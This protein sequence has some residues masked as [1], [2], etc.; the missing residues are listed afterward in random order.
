MKESSNKDL[1]SPV[2]ASALPESSEMKTMPPPA[3]DIQA[4]KEGGE[5]QLARGGR[6]VAAEIANSMAREMVNNANSSVCATIKSKWES[7]WP[8]DKLDALKMWADMVGYGKP[9]DHKK[10]LL[11]S[12]GEWHQDP[13]NNVQWYFDIWSNIHYG[14][15]GRAC[16][17]GVGTL[18]NG[19]GLAQL[20]GSSVPGGLKGWLE[21]A[22]K[23][24]IVPALDD[25]SDQ[26]ACTIGTVLWGQNFDGNT[27][28][29]L[30]RGGRNNLTHR[31]T[32]NA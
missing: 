22:S 19:A 9:W 12:Y 31:S 26:Y 10:F 27:L 21:R 20:M 18:L 16:G 13:E 3:L 30:M 32:R 4:S 15:V 8:N 2:A 29:H 7:W 14:Y 17:F 25:S 6:N 24:G 28:R 23:H 5:T 11:D 1:G